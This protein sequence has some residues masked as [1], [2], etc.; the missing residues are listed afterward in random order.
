MAR[1]LVSRTQ[2]RLPVGIHTEVKN[3]G[4]AGGTTTTSTG[5]QETVFARLQA[6]YG[7]YP[8]DT[9]TNA[10]RLDST[11]LL[12]INTGQPLPAPMEV[13]INKPQQTP[14]IKTQ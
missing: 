11:N 3:I 9:G 10:L 6:S 14:E 4:C 8:V 1:L 12:F 7:D 5:S 13:W 2:S